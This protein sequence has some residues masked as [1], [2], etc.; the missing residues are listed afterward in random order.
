MS[1]FLQYLRHATGL[2]AY[3]QEHD[4]IDLPSPWGSCGTMSVTEVV[5]ESTLSSV[6]HI[7]S[8]LSITMRSFMTYYVYLGLEPSH[9]SHLS[10]LEHFES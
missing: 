4:S 10:V 9:L 1:I 3:I 6:S 8:L 7:H 5:N 2:V